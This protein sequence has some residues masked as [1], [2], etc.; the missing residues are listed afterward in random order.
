MPYIQKTCP[1]SDE[2]CRVKHDGSTY[3][4]RLQQAVSAHARLLAAG[5]VLCKA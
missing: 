1:K 5:F 2:S 4:R 3:D